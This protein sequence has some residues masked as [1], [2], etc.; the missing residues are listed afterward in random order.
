MKNYYGKLN[1]IDQSDFQKEK[2]NNL[3]VRFNRWHDKQINL[4]TFLIN[5]FFTL[6]IATIGFIITNLKNELFEKT[7]CQSYSLGRSISTV[8]II[9][10]ITGVLALFFRLYDFR[11]TKDKIKF[12]KL[13]FRVKEN[14]KYEA[15]KE[16][17]EASCQIEIY[18][19]DSR[20]MC[21]RKLTWISFYIQV[22]TYLIGVIL[23]VF[24][25]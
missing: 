24:Y 11:Y 6:S 3:T 1:L 5:L 2:L 9:S 12:R 18:K 13:K 21:F 25:L 15:S 23:I 16:W 4:L 14:L 7:I 17:T 10:V 19:Y 22:I 8:L 20:M